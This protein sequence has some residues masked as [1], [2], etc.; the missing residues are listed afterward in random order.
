MVI[1]V[2]RVA[3]GANGCG[4]AGGGAGGADGTGT[5]DSE[6]TLDSATSTTPRFP[7]EP[8]S[9][10]ICRRRSRASRVLRTTF[11]L[12]RHRRRRARNYKSA[13]PR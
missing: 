5:E 9:W 10:S 11:G 3:G 12:D 8:R 2:G 13:C 4:S 1:R 6:T 7:L